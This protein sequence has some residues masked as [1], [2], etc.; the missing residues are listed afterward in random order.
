MRKAFA[1]QRLLTFFQQKYWHILDIS[2]WNYNET[3]TT[4][5]VS[6]EQLGPGLYHSKYSCTHLVDCVYHLL[7]QTR[8][9]PWALVFYHFPMQSSRKQ[10]LP[11]REKCN[12]QPSYHL[13]VL[14]ST[15]VS[16]ATYQ[17]WKPSSNWFWRRFLKVFTIYWR[18]GRFNHVTWT[19]WIK[20][21]SPKP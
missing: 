10:I 17:V 16:D 15:R 2:I 20:F 7:H 19:A 13:N 8:Q 9:V 1:L 4:A 12:G 21:N 14:G 11:C 18:G 5:V 3:L 6:F